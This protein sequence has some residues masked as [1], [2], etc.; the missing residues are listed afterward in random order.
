[1]TKNITK[2]RDFLFYEGRNLV[3]VFPQC[4]IFAPVG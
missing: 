4:V 1:V 3:S 2:Y